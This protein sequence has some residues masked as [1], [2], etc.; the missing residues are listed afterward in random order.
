MTVW[1][2]T[3]CRSVEIFYLNKQWNGVHARNN[4]SVLWISGQDMQSTGAALHNL[5]HSH[6][7]LKRTDLLVNLKTESQSIRI[8]W[9]LRAWY[10]CWADEPSFCASWWDFVSKVTSLEMASASLNGDWFSGHRARLRIRPT[11]AWRREDLGSARQG[12]QQWPQGCQVHSFA[13]KLV[14]FLTVA[15]CCCAFCV[16]SR[17]IL[18]ISLYYFKVR[19]SYL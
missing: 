3:F 4:V 9:T 14:Y 18:F 8:I 6:A 10:V 15:R 17:L 19:W 1:L 12:H 13:A 16:Y 2:S 5:L 11:T 7:I